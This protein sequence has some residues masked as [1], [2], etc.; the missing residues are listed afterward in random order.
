LIGL[1]T[2]LSK[3]A[4]NLTDAAPKVARKAKATALATE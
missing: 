4:A 2:S 3:A 1:L